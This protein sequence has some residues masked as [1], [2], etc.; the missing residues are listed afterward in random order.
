MPAALLRMQIVDYFDS[1]INQIDLKAEQLLIEL[2]SDHEFIN[3]K[4]AEFIHEIKQIEAYNLNNLNENEP[5]FKKFA[6][7]IDQNELGTYADLSQ[8]DSKFGYLVK[9]DRFITPGS[10]E[11][12]REAL[13]MIQNE[14]EVTFS[15]PYFHLYP[16]VCIIY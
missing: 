2:P 4:R 13:K 7:I 6:F 11:C 1:L 15:N 5:V 10:L 8:I 12:F 14:T 3:S 16:N 9:M